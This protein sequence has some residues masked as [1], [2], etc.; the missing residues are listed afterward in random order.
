[1]KAIDKHRFKPYPPAEFRTWL[2]RPRS[3]Q[4]TSMAVARIL[5]RPSRREPLIFSFFSSR[6]GPA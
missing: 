3:L 1:M 2:S 4:K 6:F 5:P